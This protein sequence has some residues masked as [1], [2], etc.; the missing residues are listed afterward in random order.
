MVADPQVVQ[1]GYPRKLHRCDRTEACK[2]LTCGVPQLQKTEQR[3]CAQFN[4]LLKKH[5]SQVKNNYNYVDV[6]LKPIRK[7]CFLSHQKH[8]GKQ[9]F[10][11]LSLSIFF[12][13][14][15]K[16]WAKPFAFKMFLI[17]LLIV[18]FLTSF[19][20]SLFNIFVPAE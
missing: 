3:H 6:S 12:S 7:K 11:F 10:P 13:F 16:F 17:L 15:V 18:P 2:T 1:K 9:T 20:F 5:I 8:K 19:N 14:R 4:C